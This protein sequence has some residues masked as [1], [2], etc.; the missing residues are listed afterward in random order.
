MQNTPYSHRSRSQ[1]EQTQESKR[2]SNQSIEKKDKR[3]Q[4]RRVIKAGK[5]EETGRK[6]KANYLN[7]NQEIIVKEK[8]DSI[9]LSPV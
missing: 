5:E 4:N 6:K 9:M 3:T 1:T 7:L 8:T 2:Y